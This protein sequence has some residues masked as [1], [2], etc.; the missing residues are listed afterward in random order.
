MGKI[1]VFDSGLGSLSIINAIQKRLKA[2]I[3]YL[4]DQK[5]YPYGKKTKTDL[6]KIIEHTITNLQ[7][8]FDPDLIVVGSNTP[9]LL[10]TEIFDK[11]D[12]VIGVLPPLMEAQQRTKTNS[13]G[14]LATKSV[15][16]SSELDN[17]IRKHTIKNGIKFTKINSSDLVDLVES[18]KFITEKNF[19]IKKIT[20]TLKQKFITNNID[21]ATLSSTHLPFL[22]SYLQKL[23]P[24]ITF[25]DP[26]DK[27]VDQIANH[28]KFI[29]SEKNTLKI[30]TT[31]NANTLKSNLYNIGIK[32]TVRQ[33]NF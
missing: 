26:A 19:C 10:V 12:A 30:F 22:A 18:G 4:A 1:A 13:I 23:F 5:N 20:S 16:N 2:D 6:K 28:R 9:S 31:G 33:I 21:V 7:I 15:V 17:Y 3:V 8:Q 32:K 11:N 29:P 27:V 25:L 14:I 24:Q